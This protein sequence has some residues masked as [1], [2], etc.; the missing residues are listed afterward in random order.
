MPYPFAPWR[1][2]LQPASYGGAGFHV[3]IGAQAGGRRIAL[4][5]YPKRDTPYAED[6][7]RKA[8][9]WTLSAYCIGPNYIAE[10]DAVIAACEREGAGT[11]I[12]PTLGQ[13]QAVVEGY[14]STEGRERGG[15]VAFELAFVESGQA[16]SYAVTDDT[17]S[18]V[19]AAGTS[20]DAAAASS[21]DS[22]LGG[23]GGIGSDAVASQES[24]ASGTPYG[25]GGI[26]RN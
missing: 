12:H 15:F 10:R 17:Q 23:S 25:S 13:M 3:E 1:E 16:A 20:S 18:Q 2:A 21:L 5:E 19:G 24:I 9:R 6:M 11:L 26:G 22:G 7:G 14:Q 4:H 8:R